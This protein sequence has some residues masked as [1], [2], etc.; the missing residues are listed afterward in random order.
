MARTK[1][2]RVPWHMFASLTFGCTAGMSLRSAQ[3]CVVLAS[4]HADARW[5][6]AEIL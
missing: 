1:A 6:F 5:W 4:E 2:K 3:F